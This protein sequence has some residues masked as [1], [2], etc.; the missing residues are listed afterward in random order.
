[1]TWQWLIINRFEVALPGEKNLE[2][3][4]FCCLS[5]APWV[6]FP[7]HFFVS[8]NITKGIRF[9]NKWNK[10]ECVIHFAIYET[11]ANTNI[12]FNH[13]RTKNICHQYYF[14][15]SNCHPKSYKQ[16]VNPTG[17][18]FIRNADKP[19]WKSFQNNHRLVKQQLMAAPVGKENSSHTT[20]GSTEITMEHTKQGDKVPS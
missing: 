3:K 12:E 18:K 20:K 5:V 17:P 10:T 15:N 14:N 13:A 2:P 16:P 11:D 9:S 6:G 4:S 19:K 7:L 8:L 1:M